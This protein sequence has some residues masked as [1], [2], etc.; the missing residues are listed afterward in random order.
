MKGIADLD[1]DHS[2]DRLRLVVGT[3]SSEACALVC[4]DAANRRV[5]P[6]RA[7]SISLASAHRSILNR[8]KLSYR[9]RNP[10]L[11]CRVSNRRE[12]L[13]QVCNDELEF[14]RCRR[15]SVMWRCADR[16]D[17]AESLG[18]APSARQD[19]LPLTSVRHEAYLATPRAISNSNG[20]PRLRHID[21]DKD[22]CIPL[23][24]SSACVRI[25]SATPSNPRK[26]SV[27]RA[28]STSKT[29]IRSYVASRLS[30]HES[31]M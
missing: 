10:R 24:G 19:Q 27:G 15:S 11:N 20:V 2:H 14:R 5:R 21:S 6:D 4:M 18:N 25:G 1:S 26:G 7:F 17:V 16:G 28:A 13:A 29:D 3:L 9:V 31:A 22:F 30:R 23:H 12:K 8:W